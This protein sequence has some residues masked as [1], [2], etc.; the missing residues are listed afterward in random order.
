MKKWLPLKYLTVLT[1]PLTVAVSF[2]SEGWATFFPLMYAFGIIPLVELV[3]K[4]NHHNLNELEEQEALDNKAYDII[5]YAILPIQFGFLIW[6]LNILPGYWNL[7]SIGHT[8]SMG[9]MCGVLGINVAHELGHRSKK[10]EQVFAQ[11]LLLSS[12]YMHFFIEHNRGHHKNVSTPEDPASA[13]KYENVYAFFYRSI[14]QSYISAWKLEFKRL[15][16]LQNPAL[17]FKNEMLRFQLI[18]LGF[19]ILVWWFFGTFATIAFLIA[20]F[21]GILLLET[22]NYIEHYGLS[23]NKTKSGYY[24]RP[25]PNHSWNSDHQMG[26]L[27]LFELSRHSDHHYKAS[28]KYQI[29]KYHDDAPQMPTGYPGMML[30]AL[31]P[32]LWFY[33]MDPRLDKATPSSGIK[34]I[35]SYQ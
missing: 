26:R 27:L 17:S 23:R 33:I 18:Q 31:V 19:V 3:L 35:A 30:L 22:V 11:L 28:R 7:S 34:K 20:A 2:L 24:E 13:R 12:M 25:Q 29:L 21:I 9:L 16:K 32:P 6:F 8:V 15:R 1:L 10:Y 5:I 14:T 4:P